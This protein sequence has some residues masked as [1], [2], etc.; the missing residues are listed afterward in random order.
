M[1]TRAA[2]PLAILLAAAIAVVALAASSSQRHIS[3][4]S[5]TAAG[6]APAG[7]RIAFSLTL[8][9][10]GAARLARALKAIESPGSP[11]FRHFIAPA[12]QGR[13]F[14]LPAAAITAL[15]RTLTRQG[16]RVLA[17]YPQRTSLI[18]G[19]SVATIERLLHTRLITY[20]D[21]AGHRF[22]A[23]AGTPVVPA[24][25]RPEVASVTGLDTRPRFVAHD[26]PLGGLTP[27]L[28]ASAYDVGPL[29]AA[30]GTGAGQTIGVLSFS[31]F[32]PSD[33]RAFA[34]E[35]GING[36]APRVVSVDGGT[37]SQAGAD[38]ANLDIDVIRS[39]APQAQIVVYEVPQ[40]T[41]AYTD[42]INRMVADHIHVISSSWGECERGVL[43]S[44]RAGDTQALRAAVAA[45]VTLFVSSGDSGA[46]DCQRVVTADHDL[47]VDWPAA[48]ADAVGVGGTRLYVTSA[49]KYIREAGWEDTLSQ[50]GGGG[51][52]TGGDA[53]PSWQTGPSVVNRFSNGKRQVPDVA[54]DADPGTPWAL[55]YAGQP[56]AA[57]GTS[58]AAP[59]WAA[60]MLLIEQYTQSHGAGLPGYVNPVLYALASSAQQFPPFHDVTFGGN[61]HYP[62]TAGWDFAT[63]LGSPDVFNLARDMVTY[64]RSHGQR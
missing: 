2:L 46:Y 36:P 20:T 44:Q 18:V 48:S 9:Q 42:A 57:G 21:G 54:A 22:H 40:T 34:N 16:L 50:A 51:G 11:Q 17:G 30:G 58:A 31:D 53:R 23:P 49:G 1:R 4:G 12:A 27:S 25:L 24:D 26:V 43:T 10:P 29:R 37:R 45:G 32:N 52:L 3:H 35:N 62:A 41:A 47:T 60:S 38:E 8:R 61:R 13:R 56:A 6:P 28:A 33:P 59:F 15:E 14:G 55:Y 39:I 63:G 5:P 19:G 64:L 7:Q